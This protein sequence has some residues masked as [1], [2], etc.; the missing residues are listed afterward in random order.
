MPASHHHLRVVGALLATSLLVGCAGDPERDAA[1]QRFLVAPG[2]YALFNCKQLAQQ[3]AAN[4][5][6]Q[7]ELEALMV[8]AGPGSGGQVVSALAYR[9]DYLQLR[10]E[11]TDMRRTA[12]EKKCNFVPGEGPEVAAPSSSSAIR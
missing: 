11:M 3:A 8:R 1:V 6:R 9:P 4:M 12:V 5:Q 10:G 2:K 7:R